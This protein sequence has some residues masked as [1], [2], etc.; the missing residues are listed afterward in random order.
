MKMPKCF[1][2]L[3]LLP[4][5][6]TATHFSLLGG[7]WPGVFLGRDPMSL[8]SPTLWSPQ[9]NL[10]FTFTASHVASPPGLHAWMPLI[11]TYPQ[12]LSLVLEIP[13]PLSWLDSK[14]RKNHMTKAAKFCYPMELEFDVFIELHLHQPYV[15]D[16][17]LYWVSFSVITF[18]KLDD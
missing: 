15:I 5:L 14:A 2:N 17:F 3:P 16:A 11:H 6:L 8:A 1:P 4:A 12:K 13:Q 18:Q 7:A 9:H 10:G